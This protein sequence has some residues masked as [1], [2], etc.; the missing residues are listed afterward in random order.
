MENIF[1][2]GIL[3]YGPRLKQLGDQL[4]REERQIYAAQDLTFDPKWLPIV[5]ALKDGEAL[6]LTKLAETLG[7][8]HPTL[9][10]TLS[11]LEKLDFVKSHKS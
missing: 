1:E 3:G 9:I 6:A 2:L 11:E 7:M 5:F 4:N 10:Q 8:A